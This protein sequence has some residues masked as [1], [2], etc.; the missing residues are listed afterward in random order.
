MKKFR[1]LAMLAILFGLAAC[2]SIPSAD[3]DRGPAPAYDVKLLKVYVPRSLT[4]S[5]R[6][7]FYPWSDINWR[8]DPPGDRYEQVAAIFQ[9]A[10]DRSVADMTEGRPVNVFV[11]AYRF[12][13]LTERARALIGGVHSIG[14]FLTIQDARTGDIIDGPHR[15]QADLAAYGGGRAIE[16]DLRGQTQKVRITDHL[17]DVLDRELALQPQLTSIPIR[18]R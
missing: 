18:G 16:S 3:R 13:S 8:G 6:D 15:I 5:E 11:Q 14:F 9:A 7:Q 4:V 1:I 2:T 10:G 17:V 12:H